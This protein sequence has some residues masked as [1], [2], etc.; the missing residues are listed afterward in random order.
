M[1]VIKKRLVN[2]EYFMSIFGGPNFINKLESEVKQRAAVLIPLLLKE[3]KLHVLLTQRTYRVSSHKGDVAFPGGKQESCD[4]D[5]ISTALREAD[6]EVG[7]KAENVC[8]LG[9]LSPK[10]VGRGILVTPVVGFLKSSDFRASIDHVEVETVFHVPLDFFLDNSSNH[11]Y[12]T[13]KYNNNEYTLHFFQ[14]TQNRNDKEESYTIYGFTAS[15]CV[16][17]AVVV[18]DRLPNYELMSQREK[19]II[20]EYFRK[21]K[22]QRKSTL[23]GQL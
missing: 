11:C 17:V 21:R 1:E 5:L 22:T 13:F 7:I 14:F 6:E 15:V 4:V 16:E 3:A 2:Y 10:M 23:K 12:E 18:L 19:N 9:V 20:K 8:I